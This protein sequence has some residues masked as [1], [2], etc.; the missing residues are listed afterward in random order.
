MHDGEH[1]PR[2][3]SESFLTRALDHLD[4]DDEVRH[5][6]RGPD[7]EVVLELPIRRDDGELA[8]FHGFRVQHDNN[9]GP[10]KGGLRYHPEMDT[11]HARG[12]ATVMTWKTAVVGIPMGGA[13]GGID[14]N[15]R[16]LSEGELETLTKRF[17]EKMGPLFGPDLDIPA[18]DVGTGPREMA[19]IYSA[20]G[21]MHEGDAPGVVTGKP[22]EVGGSKGRTA[23]TGRGVAM[24][25]D[26]A[27][28]AEGIG[29]EGATVAIQG[30]GN[31]GS[32]LAKFLDEMGAKVV[33]TS[34]VKGGIHHADGLDVPTLF[35]Q[36][37]EGEVDSV[38]ES[39]VPHEDV[40]NDELMALDVDVLVP[41]ALEHAIDM[42]NVDDVSAKMVM[43]AANLPVTC[44]ADLRLEERGIPVVPDIL[45]N[46]GGV[47][48]SYLEWVQNRQR[49]AWE[50]ARVNEELHDIMRKAWETV[51][52][53]AR[54]EGI[55]YR[56]A[57]YLV[58]VERVRDATRLRGF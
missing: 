10:F 5:L 50:E 40:T 3:C 37:Q 43:E 1:T 2:E 18:P 30:F 7:R 13:K 19:W 49:Y 24:V 12:L 36:K 55:S 39:D 42:D 20:Y 48:V 53:R 14:C 32:Y 11:D 56:L 15:P 38:V 27:C 8:V 46:A 52:A 51:S 28:E 21:S 57:S 29:L 35:R 23:A 58:A 17:V 31:V 34:D 54:D 4:L 33:A 41:A 22:I 16:E 26:W 47:T 45:A 25:T 6:L 44:D 9:R